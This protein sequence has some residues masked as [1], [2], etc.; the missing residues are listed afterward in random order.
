M[1]KLLNDPW[2]IR[3]TKAGTKYEDAQIPFGLNLVIPIYNTTI[4]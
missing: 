4:F 3:L 2:L 1:R